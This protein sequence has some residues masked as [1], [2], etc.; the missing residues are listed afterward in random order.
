[1]IKNKTKPST[2]KRPDFN[3]AIKVSKGT[4][5][6]QAFQDV[7]LDNLVELILQYF[8]AHALSIAF[9]ELAVPVTVQ[10]RNIFSSFFFLI[11]LIL[12]FRVC[13]VIF[14]AQ[15]FVKEAEKHE[16]HEKYPAAS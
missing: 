4:L 6:T 8:N 15:T 1:V 13:F 5:N 10:V 3:I 11:C 12:L 14:I 7:V 16:S 2:E 9:P